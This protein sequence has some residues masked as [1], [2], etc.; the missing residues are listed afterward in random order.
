MRLGKV[1][2]SN[3]HCDYIVQVDD[4][5][6]FAEAPLP[7]DYGF[8]T[9]VKLED[10]SRNGGS[11]RHWAVGIVYN[12]QLFNPLFLNSG[13]RLTSEPDPLF[14]PDQVQE[15]RTLLWTVLVGE[16]D[17]HNGR[18]YGIQGIP[19]VVVP[20]NTPVQRMTW[21]EIYHF[22]LNKMGRSQFCYYSH[23]LHCGGTFSEQLTHQV[24]E[25]LIE[26]K[27]FQGAEE[28]ALIVLCKE[29]AWKTTMG[30]MK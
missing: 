27:L 16:L 12:S 19:R 9:F 26:S 11:S 5:M 3:S 15:V 7:D 25:E 13:I 20:V 1:V 24:L 6:D 8:G 2:K 18:R 23:L 21:E 17:T 28:R 30:A 22:H 29:L 14:T 4:V 10:E